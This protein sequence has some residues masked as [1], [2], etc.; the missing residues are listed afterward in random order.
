MAAEAR[1]NR[2]TVAAKSEDASLQPI[3]YKEIK[4][5]LK[6]IQ[7]DPEV[8]RPFQEEDE[9][10]AVGCGCV[11]SRHK[12]GDIP[13]LQRSLHREKDLVLFLTQTK[14]DF[15]VSNH[16]RMLRTI[17]TKLTRNKSCPS[18]GA[19]WE[20]IGFQGGDP[21]TDI[22]RYGGVFNILQ[23]FFFLMHHFPIVKECYVLSRDGEQEFPMACI[24]INI[25]QL[26][27]EAFLA[28]CL[29]SVCNKGGSLLETL[30]KLHNAGLFCFYSLFRHQKRTIQ[31]TDRTKKE[32]RT[33]L[34]KKP[35]KLLQEFTRGIEDDRKRQDPTKLEFTNIDFGTTGG[36]GDGKQATPRKAPTSQTAVP[37][38]LRNYSA[39]DS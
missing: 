19:H 7:V 36:G 39:P 16:F 11:P 37:A 24:S 17:Y 8:L 9:D 38:R 3:S 22:N 26:V 20:V 33:L 4:D 27:M 32:I 18:I 35:A 15:N 10:K 1:A 29:S 14:F 30:C 6:D 2:G 13:R 34:M 21:R 5:W 23:L 28:G 31:D 25:T 12:K